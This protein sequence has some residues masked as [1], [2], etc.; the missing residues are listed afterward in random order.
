MPEPRRRSQSPSWTAL[1]AVIFTHWR[2]VLNG[3][4]LSQAARAGYA[5]AIS[6]HLDYCRLNGVSVTPGS[7]RGYMSDAERRG[8][9]H[10]HVPQA[11]SEE[12]H[13]LTACQGLAR[14]CPTEVRDSTLNIG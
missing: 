6:G 8:L 5:L 7:A 4:A 14:T 1:P 9:A 11:S 10:C 13:N 3:L 12:I 2:E